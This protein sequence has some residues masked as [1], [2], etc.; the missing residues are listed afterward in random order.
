MSIPTTTQQLLDE[1]TGKVV[2]YTFNGGFVCLSYAISLI[3]TSTALELIRRRT[4][5]RGRHNFLLLV[6]AAIA[7]G[8]IAIWSMHFIGNR[9]IYMLHGEG[10]F[11]IAY[12]T[13]L[14]V[15][16]LMMPILVLVL[17]FLGV[18][19]NSR[20]RWW[21]IV[22][23]GLLSGGAICG[24]HYLANSSISNYRSSYR[25]S[26][27]IG[28][29]VI[30]VLA[31]T[32][33]LTLF[34]VFENTWS[35]AWWK[36]LG[37][38]MV[39]AGAVS[40]MHW[41]AAVGTSYTLLRNTPGKGASRRDAMVVV[42]CLSISAGVVMTG[43]AIYSS[44]VRRDYARKSQKVVLAAGVFDDRG[45]IMVS[46]DGYLP[47]EVVTDTYFAKSNDDVFNTS[48]PL[49]LWMFRASRNW[50]T[51]TK[52]MTKMTSHISFL[53]Q[54][55]NNGRAGVR[56][57]SDDGEL[58]DGY[59][60]ILHELF[61]VSAG[62]L[63]SKTKATLIS[64]GTLWDEIFVTGE[65][66]RAPGPAQSLPNNDSP[67]LQGAAEKGIQQNGLEY[68]RGSLMFL[69]RKVDSKKEVPRLEA[70]GFRFAE[71]HQV[72]GFIRSSMHIK[73]P[74][75]ETR[76]RNMS[77]QK[78]K[79]SML[80]S[81]LHVGMFAVRARIDKG[82]FDVLVQKTARNLLPSV[83]LPVDTLDSSSASFL[84]GLRGLPLS[85][86][87]LRLQNHQSTSVQ[88]RMF[89][90]LLC[91]AV[92]SLRN[93]LGDEIF[94]EA[95]LLSKEV[96]LPCAPSTQGKSLSKCTL[97]AF[98]LFLPIHA[99]VLSPDCEFTPLNFFKMRQLI[100]DGSSH[101]IEFSHMV[102]RDISSTTH[103]LSPRQYSAATQMNNKYFSRAVGKVR[104]NL[105]G[106]ERRA[107][108]ISLPPTRSQERLSKVASHPSS[109][110]NGDDGSFDDTR[111][112]SSTSQLYA[113][114]DSHRD[115]DKKLHIYGGIMVSKEVSINVQDDQEDSNPPE[116]Q[117][118]ELKP[119]R[120]R[121]DTQGK[122]EGFYTATA[123][124]ES[125][126]AGQGKQEESAFVDELLALSM[127]ADKRTTA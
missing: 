110:Y 15:V 46:Q 78:D 14:T 11:Q 68:G 26:Y 38:A 113:G 10:A 74:D 3:G 1:Y 49:F 93:S 6:G 123:T 111:K 115:Q 48:H 57:I 17:A 75:L 59:D 84:N 119:M 79:T 45:R 101:N 71:I 37:C 106:N 36:R 89:A 47:S 56:L 23:A 8:G 19:G 54:E 81:G 80:S 100:Y 99:T 121:S 22:F 33:A 83:P 44:W 29:V 102:H 88:G 12:S 86:V 32:T 40:G 60:T 104:D 94:N 55:H 105:P 39:L 77:S 62:A 35:S 112:L 53:A 31:S 16:S 2:P 117:G 63:A 30:A 82:G 51:I 67:G 5:H 9:A 18:N 90:S 76:L 66:S 34:F 98:K 27:L 52:V 25:L 28:S 64:A 69:V 92:S 42:I 21:R 4:S 127:Q 124:G 70:S 73:T 72:A 20:I 108:A 24:M 120:L 103:Q 13:G 122:M 125:G 41:C 61:C 87:L 58:V 50:D 96:K 95:T 7:M 43:M 126:F 85:T 109:L 65:S 107:A 114:K 91:D 118:S 97:I 116:Q